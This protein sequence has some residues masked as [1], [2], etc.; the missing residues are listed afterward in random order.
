MRGR[1]LFHVRARLSPYWFPVSLTFEA[2]GLVAVE[3]LGVCIRLRQ[4]AKFADRGGRCSI[5][6]LTIATCF[7]AAAIWC[8][9]YTGVSRS[10]R[11][12]VLC[13]L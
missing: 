4:S 10:N 7:L 12:N 2:V 1:H 9:Q 3:A 8:S 13:L 11:G 5:R 6:F